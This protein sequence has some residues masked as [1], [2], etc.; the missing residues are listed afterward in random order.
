MVIMMVRLQASSFVFSACGLIAVM[1]PITHTVIRSLKHLRTAADLMFIIEL[2]RRR[3]VFLHG[4]HVTE[5]FFV[6]LAPDARCVC[7]VLHITHDHHDDQNLPVTDVLIQ[8]CL[9]LSS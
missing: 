1:D 7:S 5:M 3:H 2:I 4:L 6:R 9:V 8:Y